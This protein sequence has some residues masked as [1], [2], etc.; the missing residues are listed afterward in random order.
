MIF[1]ECSAIQRMNSTTA[2][3][4]RPLTMA[5]SWTVA[6]SSLAIGTGPVRRTV[7]W[8][9]PGQIE[10]ARGLADGVGRGLAGLQR[11]EIQHRP[12]RD[13][14]A[15][16]GGGQRIRPA[17]LLPGERRR[18]IPERLFDGI[19]NHGQGAGQRFA[20]ELIPLR[21]TE[22]EFQHPGQS[23]QIGVVDQDV[24]DRST[25]TPAGRSAW[26]RPRWEGKAGHCGRRTDR[27]RGSGPCRTC[28]FPEPASA[29][30]RGQ[31][32]GRVPG[33]GPRPRPG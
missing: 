11:V 1:G 30:G 15:A 2:T 28:P 5:P 13:Q 17:D 21:A 25:R 4:P 24:E 18:A 6:N 29:P 8:Y 19:G 14:H 3:V 26:R 12:Q 20:R 22:P 7:A 32:D 9:L 27:R 31:P 16:I 10:I 23:P 33:S